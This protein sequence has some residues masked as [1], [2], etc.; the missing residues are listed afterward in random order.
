M[1]NLLGLPKNVFETPSHPI[2]ELFPLMA[3]ED[4]QALAGDIKR[5]GMHYPIIIYDGKV[6]DGRNRLKACKLAGVV[7]HFH[8]FNAR[9]DDPLRF[10]VSANLHRRHLTQEQKREVIAAVLKQDPKRS[11]RQVAEQTK[12]DHKTVGTV[13]R[14]MEATGE[15]PQT[16]KTKG[17]DGRE[18]RQKAATARRVKASEEAK[19]NR[20]RAQEQARRSRDAG[21]GEDQAEAK[22]QREEAKKPELRQYL[23]DMTGSIEGRTE[24]LGTVDADAWGHF[25]KDSPGVVPRLLAASEALTALLKKAAGSMAD[26]PLFQPRTREDVLRLIRACIQILKQPEV[27]RQTTLALDHLGKIEKLL[28]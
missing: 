9:E 20:R 3:D 22:R 26:S 14:E 25:V 10:V 24:N 21:N 5:D 15:I 13:R 17:K 8:L 6:L 18:R 7:P 11:N 23:V 2:A 19:E 12:A 16:E 4:L 28:S 1:A 27:K